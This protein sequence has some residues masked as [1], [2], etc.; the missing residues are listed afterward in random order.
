[1]SLCH[2]VAA[3]RVDGQIDSA[4]AAAPPGFDE[5]RVD[6]ILLLVAFERKTT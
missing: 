2:R 4:R 3:A 6:R 1:M 5:L